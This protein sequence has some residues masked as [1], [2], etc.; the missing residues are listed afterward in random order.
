MKTNINES[1]AFLWD[2][3]IFPAVEQC[4]QE[5]D[6]EFA[7]L[8][9]ITTSL[10]DEYQTD[11]Y[12]KFVSL[13]EQYKEVLH[14]DGLAA[15]LD[16]TK[17]ASIVC[18]TLIENKPFNFALKQ[19]T[20]MDDQK[21]KYLINNILINYKIALYSALN[22]TYIGLLTE[23]NTSGKSD[24][25]CI[26]NKEAF[27]ALSSVASLK[28]YSVGGKKRVDAN[29][30]PL[31]TLNETLIK[32]LYFLDRHNRDFDIT[33]YAVILDGLREYT[34]LYYDKTTKVS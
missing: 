1:F 7:E 16:F 29:G 30:R 31:D 21:K 25:I 33:A 10:S 15:S 13:R 20:V 3:A 27:D 19:G 9:L 12:N 5:C 14:K 4:V 8:H 32:N 2:N 26:Q 34:R 6:L 28:I 17:L 11:I 22:I 24:T 18:Y 23:Y